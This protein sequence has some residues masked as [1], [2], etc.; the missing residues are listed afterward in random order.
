[1]NNSRNDPCPCDSGKKYKKCCLPK[2]EEAR[3][4]NRPEPAPP[5]KSVTPVVQASSLSQPKV[6]LSDLP[7]PEPDPQIQALNALWEDFEQQDYEGRISL[8]QQTL[9]KPE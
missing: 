7:E 5:A 3:R 4:A 2:D 1:M 9:D 6:D 8:F